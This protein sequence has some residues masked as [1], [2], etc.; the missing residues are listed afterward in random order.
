[1]RVLL[2]SEG[3]GGH[4]VPALEVAQAL[5][6]RSAAVDVW[7]AKRAKADALVQAL[8]VPLKEKGI[9]VSSIEV[10]G[11]SGLAGRAE[12][13]LRLA[14]RTRRYIREAHPAAVVGFGGW[15]SV[16]VLSAA[17]L[18][19]VPTLLHEQNAVLGRAN[20]LSAR[21]VDAVATAFA[22]TQGLPRRRSVLHTG[23]PVRTSFLNLEAGRPDWTR[24]GFERGRSTVL[25][26]GGSQGSRAV[27]RLMR[28][29]STRLTPQ[30]RAGWQVLHIA[31]PEDADAMRRTYA[32][33]GVRA[34]VAPHMP[35]MPSAFLVADV[36]VGRAGAS[37]LAELMVTGKPSVLIPYPYA[38]AHQM[39]NARWLV[40]K[41]LA[42]VIEEKSAT[43][44]KLLEVLRLV[45]SDGEW[46]RRVA[47]G[48]HREAVTDAAE[49]IAD[50]VFSLAG[51]HSSA[52][53]MQDAQ[54]WSVQ[55]QGARAA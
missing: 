10:S 39:A 18:S 51:K 27:N 17:R 15:V 14:R 34:F 23:M 53:R 48:L 55:T 20:R 7:Y 4:L 24:F 37:T 11:L 25:V 54:V 46:R 6:R 28:Q 32:D 47:A 9:A 49:R 36:V 19:N 16:P 1:M 2:V 22:Q 30:E 35:D 43:P 3:S 8:A 5:C 12:H 44:E 31:G 29:L 41:G 38:H 33:A 50:T 26:V 45:L 40:A 13:T 42:H 21:W 52:G